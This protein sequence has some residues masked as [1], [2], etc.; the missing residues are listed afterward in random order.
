M[1]HVA[2]VL[3]LSLVADTALVDHLLTA[4]AFIIMTRFLALVPTT[5]EES[6]TKGVTDG[7][8][9]SAALSLPSK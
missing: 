5:G 1:D 7:Y 6:F 3:R 9:L 4:H 2:R 8:W